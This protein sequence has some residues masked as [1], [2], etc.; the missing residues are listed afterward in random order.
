MKIF[1]LSFLFGLICIAAISTVKGPLK[2]DILGFDELTNAVYFTRTDWS[3]CVCETDLYIYRVDKET[4]EIIADWVPRYDFQKDR[5]GIIESK[6]LGH[7][8]PL[9]KSPLPDFI[10]FRWEPEVKYYSKV[11]LDYTTSFPFKVSVFGQDYNYLQCGKKGGDP[12]ITNFEINSNSGLVF[13]KF[14]GD[15]FEGFWYDSLIFYSN[16]NEKTFSKSLTE[17]R[18]TSVE[19]YRMEEK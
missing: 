6:G 12:E 3:E 8:S 2:I 17:K 14:Q 11:L 1:L 7:L 5:N 13:V 9:N 15:C 4:I 16:K 10:Q 18:N 19:F